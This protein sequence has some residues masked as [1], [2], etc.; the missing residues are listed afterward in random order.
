[1]RERSSRPRASWSSARPRT[2]RPRCARPPSSRRSSCS[3]TCSSRT[4]T[5]SRS[6]HV[7]RTAAAGRLLLAVSFTWFLA[8]LGN[9]N[10]A[11][12]STIGQAGQSLV[13]AAFVHLVLAY[14]AGRL[15][16]RVDRVI[17]ASGYAL[18][19]GANVL[20]LMFEPHPACAKCTTNVLLVADRPGLGRA[21]DTATNVAAAT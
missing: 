8:L 10:D 21:L 9:A 19:L 17:V 12:V 20:M 16:T 18:A 3:S 13:L 7:S 15:S 11:V 1:M 5:G 14:P 2:A 4:S 6:P